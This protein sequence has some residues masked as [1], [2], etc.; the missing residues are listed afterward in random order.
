MCLEC[1]TCCPQ[2]KAREHP[3]AGTSAN[4]LESLFGAG[5]VTIA[6][7]PST[8]RCAHQ[9]AE[10]GWHT[11]VCVLSK[12]SCV[13]K[14]DVRIIEAITSLLRSS[15]IVATYRAAAHAII[16][17]IYL[18]PHEHTV[19]RS[20]RWARDEQPAYRH[21]RILLRRVS[22]SRSAWDTGE[23]GTTFIPFLPANNVF[24]PLVSAI[25]MILKH[26]NSIRTIDHWSRYLVT[27]VLRMVQ[28]TLCLRSLIYVHNCTIIRKNRWGRCWDVKSQTHS[29]MIP[30]IFVF[31]TWGIRFSF[32]SLQF[33]VFMLLV[34][35]S[36]GPKEGFS[37][38]N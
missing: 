24:L 38:R 8:I 26:C 23:V 3:L 17:R 37:V 11:L 30:C 12:Q 20:S 36:S 7:D 18:V 19:I 16:L 35:K 27:L 22:K 33:W 6:I 29:P 1:S 2:C 14:E 15:Y 31:W 9:H 34:R 28:I 4:S 21:L 10:D 13:N 25:S 32:C 5:T